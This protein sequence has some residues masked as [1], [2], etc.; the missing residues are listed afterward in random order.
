M[1]VNYENKE[2][3]NSRIPFG[4]SGGPL[5]GQVLSNNMIDVVSP[6]C[7]AKEQSNESHQKQFLAPQSRRRKQPNSNKA[8]KQIGAKATVPQH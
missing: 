4:K 6:P 2:N 8:K 5:G 3:I 7:P 1:K